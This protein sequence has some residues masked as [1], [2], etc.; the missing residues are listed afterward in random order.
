MQSFLHICEYLGITPME[1]FN[2][3]DEC[4]SDT[5]QLITNMQKLDY[6]QTNLILDLVK[7]INKLKRK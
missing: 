7:E 2:F 3:D 1:F 6:K 4:P 5:N